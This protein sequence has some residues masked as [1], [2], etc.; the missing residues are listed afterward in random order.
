MCAVSLSDLVHLYVNHKPVQEVSLE[1]LHHAFVALGAE[2]ITG[3]LKWESLRLML[4]RIGIL[5]ALLSLLL[6]LFSLLLSAL[7]SLFVSCSFASVSS[8]PY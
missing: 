7:L 6:V 1:D 8:V 2:Q 4:L 5:S 3:T